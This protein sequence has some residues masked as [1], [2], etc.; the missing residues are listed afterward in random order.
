MVNKVGISVAS[1]AGDLDGATV[2]VDGILVGLTEGFTVGKVLLA[3]G[4]LVVGAN[5]GI[6]VSTKT[7]LILVNTITPVESVAGT[8]E[9]MM[10]S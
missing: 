7:V 2:D 3:I 5:V 10:K 6:E 4:T 9:L 8:L 1:R